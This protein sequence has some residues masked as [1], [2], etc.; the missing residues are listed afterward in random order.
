MAGVLDGQT[1]ELVGMTNDVDIAAYSVAYKEGW[2][3]YLT[4]L[5]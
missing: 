2:P 3:E 1:Q 5:W 4:S